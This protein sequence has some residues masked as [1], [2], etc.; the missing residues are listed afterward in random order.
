MIQ[1]KLLICFFNPVFIF[2][3]PF[4]VYFYHNKL[5]FITTG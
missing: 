1:I 2:K 5:G 4:P 3:K